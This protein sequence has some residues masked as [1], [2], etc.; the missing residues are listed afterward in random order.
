PTLPPLTFAP[1]EKERYPL[2]FLALEASMAGGLMP[3]VL[4]AANEKAIA[5]FLRSEISFKDILKTVEEVLDSY[6]NILNPS[7]ETI[8]ETN[9]SILQGIDILQ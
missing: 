1:I 6:E 4:N 2:Y 5:M 8:L 9:Q 3:T 7:L